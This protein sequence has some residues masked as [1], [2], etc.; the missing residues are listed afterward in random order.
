MWG[1]NVV[2]VVNKIWVGGS[3]NF[4]GATDWCM[5]FQRSPRTW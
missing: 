1:I 5:G 2:I 4:S 3:F